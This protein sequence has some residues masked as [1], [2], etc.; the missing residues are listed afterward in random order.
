MSNFPLVRY[1]ATDTWIPS[2]DIDGIDANEQVIA[3]CNNI[4]FSNGFFENEINVRTISLP[5]EVNEQI[6]SYHFRLLSART[7]RHSTQ[8]IKTVYILWNE[9]S[10]LKIYLDNVLLGY[11]SNSAETLSENLILSKPTNINYNLINDQLKINL[12]VYGN[13]LKMLN[14]E[15]ILN[16]TLCYLPKVVYV[17]QQSLISEY[18]REAGWYLIPR[19]LGWNF[20]NIVTN[21]TYNL[22]RVYNFESSVSGTGGNAGIGES[23]N[24]VRSQA[25][26][27][28][29][30][31]NG[32][33]FLK[34]VSGDKGYFKITNVGAPTLLRFFAFSVNMTS[35][36]IVRV[37]NA[38]TTELIKECSYDPVRDF[39]YQEIVVDLPYSAVG[40][41]DIEISNTEIGWGLDDLTIEYGETEKFVIV[42][43]YF[44]GQRGIVYSGKILP[45]SKLRIQKS[46]IDWRVSAYEIYHE[47]DG[48][49]V[50]VDTIEV[51]S[52]TTSRRWSEYSTYLEIDIDYELTETTLNYNYNLPNTARVDNEKMIY[53]EIAHK[54]RVY[55]VNGDYKV[56]QSH[57]STNLAIQADAFPYDEETGFGYFEVDQSKMNL[58]LANSPTNDMV[59]FTNQGMYLY[60]IQPSGSGSF[61]QLR[62]GSGSISISSIGTLTSLL[63]GEPAT[64][65]LFWIDYNGL[66][67]YN[68]GMTPPENLITLTHLR[69]W[70]NI[71]K[72]MKESAVGFY[73]P[74]K[75]EYWLFINNTFLIFELPFKKFRVSN[76]YSGLVSFVGYNDLIPYYITFNDN[77]V[78]CDGTR[79]IDAQIETHYNTVESNPEIYHKIGQTIYLEFGEESDNNATILVKVFVDDWEVETYTFNT[80]NKYDK[81]LLPVGL[82]FNRI[83]MQVNIPADKY[84]RIKEFGFSYAP[85]VAEPVGIV[86]ISIAESGY[87]FDFGNDFGN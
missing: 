4:E 62:M 18:S 51:P 19:W 20:Y 76:G 21:L 59:I 28:A 77:I 3:N 38:G 69:Y 9:S 54:G 49:S 31:H 46:A 25:T 48:V 70:Q 42:A 81:W 22:K 10:G 27:Y 52:Q 65:G 83:K 66:Y 63:N 16:F 2:T 68:G 1:K 47:I 37:F 53:S 33:W 11:F 39:V 79:R 15:V 6:S 75:K 73:N 87:G 34:S 64:D 84:V 78:A 72:E 40:Y 74:V 8:G 17:P 57:I 86:P 55:F 5:S 85:D 60:F 50:L 26:G 36:Y 43:K 14:K 71:S 23:T 32:T 58:A 67:Y 45:A 56:Y 12:N 35:K 29:Y 80:K 13:M 61:K 41:V 44:D 7:F 24:M 30:A 82:R